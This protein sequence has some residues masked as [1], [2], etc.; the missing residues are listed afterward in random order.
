MKKAIIPI[1]VV[2]I[3]AVWGGIAYLCLTPG[4]N[5]SAPSLPTLFAE[6]RA[7]VV[8]K[9]I[10]SIKLLVAKEYQTTILT[11]AGQVKANLPT[12]IT[13]DDVTVTATNAVLGLS[14]HAN[15]KA[16]SSKAY[17]VKVESSWLLKS[18]D[19]WTNESGATETPEASPTPVES[20]QV[21]A[22][23][24]TNTPTETPE[25]T[26]EDVKPLLE[27]F[28]NP[29]LPPECHADIVAYPSNDVTAMAFTPD[30]RYLV[31]ASYGDFSVKVWNTITWTE[32][33]SLKTENRVQSIAMAP[34]GQSFWTADVYKNILQWRIM[35]GGLSTPSV[36]LSDAG[37][38]VEGVIPVVDHRLQISSDIEALHLA[39]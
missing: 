11:L 27:T 21:S 38:V 25:E 17:Y 22:N 33:A 13:V 30:G 26:P 28:F 4:K 39:N 5:A 35:N 36:F 2:L 29:D 3:L 23:G 9:D 34:D 16:V 10:S 18:V 12:D 24:E 14:S 8:R 37:D 19:Q 1:L 15:G 6:Y 31:T 20:A 32:T 7:A